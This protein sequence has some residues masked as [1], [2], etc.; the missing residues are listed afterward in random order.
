VV[1]AATCSA[2]NTTG[3]GQAPALVKVGQGTFVL[4]VSAATDTVYGPNAGSAAS[5]FTNGD[6]VSVINGAACNATNHSGCGQLAATIKVGLNPQGVA[7]NDRTHTVYVA[8]NAL[9]DMPG[10]VSVINGVT[11]NGSRTSGCAGHQSTVMVGRSPTSVAVD[12]RTGT[13]YVSDSSS[14]AVSVINGSTCKA[15]VTSGCRHPARLQAVGSQPFGVSVNQLTSSVYV[16]QLFQAGS[17]SILQATRIP[18]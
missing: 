8:N 11:C 6:T 7:I 15:G 18:A 1:N 2:Q 4:A 16:T 13:V 9:G 3:C 10:T 12:T 5:H 17:M 14:A